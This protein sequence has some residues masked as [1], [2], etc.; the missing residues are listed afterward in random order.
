MGKSLK[1]KAKK[2][3]KKNASNEVYDKLLN[4]LGEYKNGDDSKKFD[5]KLQKAT[6]LFVPFIIK[7]QLHEK[8]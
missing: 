4:A 3:L 5:R 2:V 6:K 1:E 7:G 8:V